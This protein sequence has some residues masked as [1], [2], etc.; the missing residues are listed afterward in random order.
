LTGK[1]PHEVDALRLDEVIRILEP[2]KDERELQAKA[3][4]PGALRPKAIEL[5]GQG[6]RPI[7]LGKEKRTLTNAQYD[8][9]QALL[10]AGDVGL[11]KDELDRKSGHGDTRKVLKRLAD[12]DDDCS[13]VIHFPGETG[14]GYR[15]G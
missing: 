11:T 15:I 1:Y 7:V 10:S 8:A 5:R 2:P 3:R 13:K 12:S 9:V 14:K 6:Q 4:L